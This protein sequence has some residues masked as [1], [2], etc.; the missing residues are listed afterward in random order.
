MD[1]AALARRFLFAADTARRAA[2]PC[3]AATGGVGASE[4][5]PAVVAD[6][7]TDALGGS[8]GIGLLAQS[9]SSSDVPFTC[10]SGAGEDGSAAGSSI[11]PRSRV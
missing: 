11:P 10:T 1:A 2:T 4:S 7:A 9:C 3:V 6:A 5:V 8:G